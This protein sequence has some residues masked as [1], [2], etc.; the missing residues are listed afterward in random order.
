MKTWRLRNGITSS[1][2]ISWLIPAMR[3]NE[4]NGPGIV[5]EEGD[6]ATVV[7]GACA[8]SGCAEPLAPWDGV[9]KTKLQQKNRKNTTT[10]GWQQ[11]DFTAGFPSGTGGMSDTASSGGCKRE[12]GSR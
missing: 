6:A 4:R 7:A 10:G 1:G 9:A 12:R 3:R 2:E 11:E 5:N 8:E